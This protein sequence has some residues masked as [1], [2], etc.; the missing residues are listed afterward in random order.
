MKEEKITKWAIYD[1]LHYHNYIQLIAQG[2]NG[3]ILTKETSDGSEAGEFLY[4]MQSG[5]S[6]EWIKNNISGLEDDQEENAEILQEYESHPGARLLFSERQHYPV[7]GGF[8]HLPKEQ[9]AMIAEAAALSEGAEDFFTLCE[10]EHDITN[11]LDMLS[12]K[13]IEKLISLNSFSKLAQIYA[14]LYGETHDAEK[15]AS[16]LED[17]GVKLD[18]FKSF[19]AQYY[20]K[21]EDPEEEPLRG[22]HDEYDCIE[23]SAELYNARDEA[24][25]REAAEFL[26]DC[27]QKITWGGQDGRHVFYTI[28]EKK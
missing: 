13:M 11:I 21:N 18:M 2:E 20:L 9:R 1:S 23:V 17:L 8:W 26:L 28:E 14:N 25:A 6:V 5:A 19:S 4:N 10:Q 27:G 3:R 24:N 16:L 22:A 12:T 7:C 15:F